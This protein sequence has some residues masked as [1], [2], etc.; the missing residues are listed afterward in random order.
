VITLWGT[1]VIGSSFPWSFPWNK[2]NRELAWSLLTIPYW[3]LY[4]ELILNAIIGGGLNRF[5][6]I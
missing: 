2:G 5:K 6:I 4:G 3:L 1:L